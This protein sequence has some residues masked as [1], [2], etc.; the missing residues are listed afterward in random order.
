[1]KTIIEI[2]CEEEDELNLT[3]DKMLE[4]LDKRADLEKYA[5]KDV[6]VFDESQIR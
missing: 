1:M 2:E 4:T 5:Q 3:I 6:V